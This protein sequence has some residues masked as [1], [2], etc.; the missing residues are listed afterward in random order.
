MGIVRD[1]G[2]ADDVVG[3]GKAVGKTGADDP[4]LPVDEQGEAAPNSE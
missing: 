4:V 1:V 2:K 3:V